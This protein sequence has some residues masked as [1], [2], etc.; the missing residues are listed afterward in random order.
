MV[1]AVSPDVP[2]VSE[3]FHR[4]C[5]ELLATARRVDFRRAGVRRHQADGVIYELAGD[6]SQESD[7]GRPD[8]GRNKAQQSGE[9]VRRRGEGYAQVDASYPQTLGGIADSNQLES[10]ITPSVR[11]NHRNLV[12]LPLNTMPSRREMISSAADAGGEKAVTSPPV[13]ACEQQEASQCQ[14]ALSVWPGSGDYHE[15]LGWSL[16]NRIRVAAADPA[17]PGA[18]QTWGYENW[19]S[20]SGNVR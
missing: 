12:E 18:L 15:R 4:N 3:E 13:A 6:G 2:R 10:L 9:G 5:M 20:I 16:A 11:K 1:L 17:D 14:V 19:G 8:L 7:S